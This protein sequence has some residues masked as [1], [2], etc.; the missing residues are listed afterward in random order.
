MW[1]GPCTHNRL[2]CLC[3]LGA[4]HSYMHPPTCTERAPAA[5][6]EHDSS[7]LWAGWLPPSSPVVRC[8]HTPHP[9]RA[10]AAT[11]GHRAPTAYLRQVNHVSL[12]AAT[13]A[14]TGNTLSLRMALK[15]TDREV[16]AGGAVYAA[17]RH[18]SGTWTGAWLCGG[19][20]RGVACSTQIVHIVPLDLYAPKAETDTAA[21]WPS[22]QV[23]VST[24]H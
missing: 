23:V 1:T 15:N 3:S 20:G 17:P 4:H 8:V 5:R 13:C 19:A 16:M 6:L 9:H 22:C 10:H 2:I 14:A 18:A 24:D 12:K 11:C 21:C 7:C